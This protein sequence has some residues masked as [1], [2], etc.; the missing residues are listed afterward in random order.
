MHSDARGG[1]RGTI[2]V[3]PL[4]KDTPKK[5]LEHIRG[6]RDVHCNPQVAQTPESQEPTIAGSDTVIIIAYLLISTQLAQQLES[7]EYH[8][9]MISILAQ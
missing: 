3:A 1:T 8:Y 9:A 2:V 5:K 7:R 6:Y 4:S